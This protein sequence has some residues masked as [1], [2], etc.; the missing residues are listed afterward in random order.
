MANELTHIVVSGARQHN[1]KG[2]HVE[3]PKNRLVVFSGVSGSGKSSLAFDTLY[4]EGQRRYIESLSAYARQFL[5]QLEK[6]IYDHIRGLQPTISV[7]QK[8]QSKNPRSTVGT[9][10]EIHDYLRVLF[11]RVGKLH[12]YRCGKPV[13]KRS[14]A[15]IVAELLE[16]PAGSR[17]MVL[18]PLIVQRKGEHVD[19]LDRMRREGFVRVRIDGEVRELEESIA[20]DKKRKHSIDLVVDRIA[21]DEGVLGRLTDSVEMALRY[22][23]GTVVIGMPQQGGPPHDTLYSERLACAV[24]GASFPEI[25]P[26]LFSFNS[27][28]G[29][30]SDCHGLGTV[31]AM[32]PARIVVDGSLTI[33]DGAIEPW[34]ALA[35]RTGWSARYYRTVA[36]AF[37]IDLDRP[38]GKLKKDQQEILLH[39]AGGRRVQ[40][41]WSSK[42]SKGSYAVRFEGVIPQMMRRMK[43]SQSD[44]AK[45]HYARYLSD[46]ACGSCGGTR[47]RPEVLGVTVGGKTLP[48]VT[49][50]TIGEA[51]AMFGTLELLGNERIIA[52]E[53]LKEVVSRLGFLLGVGLDYL[54]LDRLAPTLS[55]GESQRIRLA[56][57][58][59]SE[60][61]GV[62]YVL[63]EPSI[64]LHQKDNDR[65]LAAL[66]HLRDI[67][68]SV[69]VV[70]HD[71]DTLMA[72]DWLVDFGP[73]AGVH[74][75]QVVEQGPP[76]EVTARGASLTARY[77]GGKL[78]IEIPKR[79]AEGGTRH[80]T[81]HGAREH[82]LQN[83]TARF[84]LGLLTC[85]TGVSGAGKSTL[86]NQTLHPALAARFGGGER[87]VGAHD[88]LT[89]AEHI[90]RLIAIDQSPIGRTPRSNP[91]TYTKLFDAIRDFYAQ[92][93][94]AKVRGYG[95]GRFSFNVKGG[96]CEACAG[97]GVKQVEMHFLADVFVTC[98]VCH[99][100]RFN[101]ATLEV[102]YKGQS[103]ADV[104][105]HTVD[106]AWELFE[107]FPVIRRVATTLRDV[108]LGYLQLG[109]PSPTLSGGEAQRIKLSRELAKRSTGSTLYLLDEPTTGLHW[110]DIQKLLDVLARLVDAGNTVIVIEHNLDVIKCADHVIDLGPDG[111]MRGGHIVAEGTPEEIAKVA[112]SYTG[113]YLK[114]VLRGGRRRKR[115][116]EP[117]FSL[118]D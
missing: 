9:I 85:V 20:L 12:C 67:G 66:C 71:P 64:G 52:A 77:L 50:M 39:G 115:E 15:E 31:V 41:E 40:V 79:R 53:V 73:G 19:V 116:R 33:N 103:I 104:L 35:K 36:K 56:S 51:H 98:E 107:S 118:D 18:A 114:R 11:A 87:R 42:R 80:L 38:W 76:R 102:R 65:L 27:P 43:E 5:G 59:G 117:V 14:A 24:C 2:I 93:P 1:L 92:L 69:V 113:R 101:D 68:N 108:G 62:L 78:R 55:G 49:A 44:T 45:R 83:V 106:E 54:A 105:D 48:E 109:Q 61:T 111:G 91:A 17:L 32:D 99:G 4:A 23:N 84:P 26:Q 47:V 6:P 100:R 63:D 34:G 22:G 70:E 82:N 81:L 3:I 90:D 94:E 58:I 96:R 110:A 95:A 57:Q 88:H 13:G 72:A 112:G 25:T 75:G 28:Q 74:G 29:M 60:L 86:V 89:G 8:A 46:A 37:D 21:I 10:T 30:C 7:E 16:L 97:A